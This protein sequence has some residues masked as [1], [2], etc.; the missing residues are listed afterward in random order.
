MLN[1]HFH[2]VQI[3]L[4]SLRQTRFENLFACGGGFSHI[5]PDEIHDGLWARRVRAGRLQ[6]HRGTQRGEPPADG[7][8][9]EP[10]ARTGNA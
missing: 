2:G 7:N 9:R 3:D 10:A 1:L 6:N 8:F 4:N 5:T